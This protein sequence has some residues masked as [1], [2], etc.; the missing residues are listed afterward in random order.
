MMTIRKIP[1]ALLMYAFFSGTTFAVCDTPDEVATVMRMT[2]K[3]QHLA[4]VVC[5]VMEQG[6]RLAE[7]HYAMIKEYS[8][9]NKMSV[10]HPV[11]EKTVRLV[12]G[13]SYVFSGACDSNCTDLD[14]VLVNADRE[15]VTK[16]TDADDHPLI[17]YQPTVTGDFTV[18]PVLAHCKTQQCA[19]A[20]L[21]YAKTE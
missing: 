8:L 4:E 6:N 9:I 7:H 19:Y 15:A 12:A 17:E 18:I 11:A 10:R 21:G 20:V 5:Q 13:I 1:F 3:D 2:D 14:I 16:D